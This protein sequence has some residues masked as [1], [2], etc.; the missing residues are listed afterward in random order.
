MKSL[1]DILKGF[2]K[3]TQELDKLI[4]SNKSVIKQ[5]DEQVRHLNNNSTVL[6]TEVA[7]A[8]AVKANIEKLLSPQS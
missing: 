3:T 4:T 2:T 5:N 1:S 8:A 7:K 6:E